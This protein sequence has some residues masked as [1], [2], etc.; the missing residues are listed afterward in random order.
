MV[1]GAARRSARPKPKPGWGD[2]QLTGLA[3][4]HLHELLAISSQIEMLLGAPGGGEYRSWLRDTVGQL[5]ASD[6]AVLEALRDLS[7]PIA[8]TNYDG[9]IEEVT[10][11]KSATWRD[12]ALVQRV[13]RG[14]ESRVLHLHGYWEQP[15]S[16]VLGAASYEK[17]LGDAH[18]QSVQAA[19]A[20][21]KSFLFVGY[22]QGLDDPNFGALLQ[23]I[24]LVLP[25][26]EY[27]HFRLCLNAEEQEIQKQHPPEER[28]FAIPYGATHGDLAGFLRSLRPTKS[29]ILKQ[30]T[31]GEPA[32]LPPRPARIFGRKEQLGDLVETLLLDAPPPVPVLGGPGFGKSTLCLAAL[33]DPQV[34]ARF[35]P[36]RWFVRCDAASTAADAVKEIALALGLPI[37]PALESGVLAA[38]GEAPA[39]VVLDNAETPWEA[40]MQKTEELLGRLSGVAKLALVVSVR[41]QQRP[42]GLAWRDAITV[43]P[44]GLADSRRIF[45][46]IVGEKYAADPYLSDLLA[47][48]EGIPLAIELLAHAAEGEPDL[49]GLRQRW[50]EERVDLLR[51]GGGSHALGKC[52]SFL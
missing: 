32:S 27:R 20:L 29:P 33:H 31:V 5:H 49:G 38:L 24:S 35:G 36:R 14:E 47:P 42:H 21:M 44:L 22:G 12:G 50:Q 43:T 28:T 48:L 4:G 39:A 8:T 6:R 34:A 37:G 25:G 17:V 52:G 30:P 1:S 46:A 13:I 40:E 18:A 45:L 15:E 7:V 3:E 19:L 10:G 9:L 51:R 2:R 11:L 41:G 23:W 16:V 26:Q